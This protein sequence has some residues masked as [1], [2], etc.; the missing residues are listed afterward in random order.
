LATTSVT[1]ARADDT[2]RMRQLA[3]EASNALLLSQ[4]A[5]PVSQP[6]PSA[7]RAAR[8]WTDIGAAQ[9][10][11]GDQQA[12]R[13]SFD[14]AWQ[15]V[16]TVQRDRHSVWLML[17]EIAQEQA[18]VGQVQQAIEHASRVSDTWTRWSLFSGIAN[19]QEARKDFAGSRTTIDSFPRAD[20]ERAAWSRAAIANSYALE[21]K[22]S[23]ALETCD[24]LAADLEL[25]NR[26]L[27]ELRRAARVL[28]PDEQ[29]IVS[30]IAAKRG[31]V[32]MIVAA[33]NRAGRFEE[34]LNAA[35]RLK[36]DDGWEQCVADIAKAAAK[37]GRLPLAQK[38]FAEIPTRWR[39]DDL[40]ASIV[41]A[42]AKADRFQEAD[43]LID[44]VAD[45]IYRAKAIFKLA[46]ARAVLG[47]DRSVKTQYDRV[48]GFIR[49]D[50]D[51]INN[52][53][54]TIGA[55]YVSGGH[56][57]KAATFAEQ[58]ESDL[59]QARPG[60][61]LADKWKLE[62]RWTQLSCLYQTVAS[63]AAQKGQPDLAKQ[64]F[65]R[66]RAAETH[67]SRDDFRLARLS[68]IALAEADAGSRAAAIECLGAAFDLAGRIDL[69]EGNVDNLIRLAAIQAV[70]GQRKV[71]HLTVSLAIRSLSLRPVDDELTRSL[72]TVAQAQA[73][74][75]DV[76][77][78]VRAARDQLSPFARASMLAGA[79]QGMAL[80]REGKD[81]LV[82][83]RL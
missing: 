48:I 62:I 70:L 3:N 58:I 50:Y 6:S 32:L 69:S 57:A 10:K 75:G 24:G 39:K 13:E 68:D 2:D 36:G 19:A 73:S 71:A 23:A 26:L 49:G 17:R 79:V 54:H 53:Q 82:R 76:D 78:A 5:E 43:R 7:E 81:W 66:C 16:A 65:E 21:Q 47:D 46:A 55:G 27:K 56:F 64:M 29:R 51:L 15:G 83:R 9:A 60:K 52:G 1:V 35:A 74:M 12:A 20:A 42:L 33:L 31:A 40:S 11:I 67:D 41:E 80:R 77:D 34:S 4:S 25:G 72:Q 8:L 45:P 37:A 61:A 38:F 14:R 18:E 30:R 63:A 59:L 22:F 44:Q 28:T